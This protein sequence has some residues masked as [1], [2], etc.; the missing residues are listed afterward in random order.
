MIPPTSIDGTD[1]TGATIDGTD[2]TEITVDGQ[3]VFTAGI[4]GSFID[5]F[6]DN[7]LTNRDDY[8]TTP[9]Q[10]TSLIPTFSSFQNPKRLEWTDTRNG[11][12]VT[13]GDLQIS[14]H[15][16]Q[17]TDTEAF[18]WDTLEF[19]FS[20]FDSNRRRLYLILY[21]NSNAASFSSFPASFAGS[22]MFGLVLSTND[23][24]FFDDRGGNDNSTVNSTWI[25]RPQPIEIKLEKT[26]GDIVLNQTWSFDLYINNNNVGSFTDTVEYQPTFF[27]F[28][29]KFSVDIPYVIGY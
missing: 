18:D 26:S 29:T 23:S 3:T 25:N 1:I 22:E 21:G 19:E 24:I 5:D 9:V 12:N 11:P 10:P 7:K 13:N 28:S 16:V 2:V 4:F 8:N 15:V 6:E 20:G 14:N 17:T 27:G